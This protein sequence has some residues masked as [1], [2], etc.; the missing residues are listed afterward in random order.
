M[1]KPEGCNGVVH[2]G[3]VQANGLDSFIAVCEFDPPG[4]LSLNDVCFDRNDIADNK[5]DDFQTF[6]F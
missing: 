1:R 4:R 2:I 3:L 5:V 6:W